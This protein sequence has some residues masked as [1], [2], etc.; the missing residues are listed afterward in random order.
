MLRTRRQLRSN[1]FDSLGHLNQSIYH[2]VLEDARLEFV[3]S[4]LPLTFK[5]VIV[6]TELEH[7]AEITLENREVDTEIGLDRLGNSSF[8]LIQRV[9]RLDGVVA[10]QGKATFAC[11]DPERRRARP[12]T[13]EERAALQAAG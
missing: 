9:I 1:D 13:E 5:F 3:H 11:W 10:A 12:L 7:R 8:T 4:R 6:H 2:I